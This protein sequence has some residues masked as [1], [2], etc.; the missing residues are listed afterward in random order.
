MIITK[1]KKKTVYRISCYIQKSSDFKQKMKNRFIFYGNGNPSYKNTEFRFAFLFVMNSKVQPKINL[2]NMRK[3]VIIAYEEFYSVGL[4]SSLKQFAELKNL[5]NIN[6]KEIKGKVRLHYNM[7]DS[8][9]SS[10]QSINH[11]IQ[12]HLSLL[13]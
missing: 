2:L 10:N 11:S 9:H 3:K 8:T 7:E 5:C 12:L 6:K 13:T 1:N 4:F